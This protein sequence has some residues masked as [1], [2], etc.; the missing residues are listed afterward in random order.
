MLSLR[1]KWRFI[2]VVH[3]QARRKSAHRLAFFNMNLG[4]W[5]QFEVVEGLPATPWC[6]AQLSFRNRRLPQ[7]CLLPSAAQI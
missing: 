5:E 1:P 4:T 2:R 6:Q 3:A 7:V